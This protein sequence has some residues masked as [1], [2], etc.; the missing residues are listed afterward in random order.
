LK[1]GAN[2]AVDSGVD[3]TTSFWNDIDGQSRIGLTWDR[4]ADERGAPTQVELSSFKIYV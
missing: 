1:A 2:V 4:G 3:L